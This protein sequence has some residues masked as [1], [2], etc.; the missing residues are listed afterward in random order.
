MYLDL[1]HAMKNYLK[2]YQKKHSFRNECL[3]DFCMIFRERCNQGVERQHATSACDIPIK[4]DDRALGRMLK[5]MEV[6]LSVKQH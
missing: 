2:K 6:M 1:F 4:I 5:L 3:K